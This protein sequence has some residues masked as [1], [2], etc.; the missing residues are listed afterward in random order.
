M[1]F[2]SQVI[3]FSKIENMAISPQDYYK[4]PTESI[5][6]YNA[7]IAKLRGLSGT[8]N[9]IPNQLMSQPSLPDAQQSPLLSFA[10][11]LKSAV[12]LARQKRNA[13][14]LGI[15]APFQGTVAASD[16]NSILSNLNR[17]SDTTAQDLIE[18][19]TERLTP[20]I[21]TQ[22]DAAGNL[23]G[24]DKMTGDVVWTAKG[25]GKP[26]TSG[27]NNPPT[28]TD[29]QVAKGAIDAGITAAEF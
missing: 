16:F 15:M 22:L 1:L 13:S 11:T 6:E 28:F 5:P 19:A 25:V 18:T 17:A 12:N 14:S 20:D 3:S 7:R 4:L 10:D 26:D 24:I 2:H 9:Q 8:Q 23:N 29:T 21:I 27:V